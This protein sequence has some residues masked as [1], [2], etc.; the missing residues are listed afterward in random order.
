MK[1]PD[2]LTWRQYI[3]QAAFLWAV[4]FLIATAGCI[5]TGHFLRA[6]GCAVGVLGWLLLMYWMC[7][8]QK[9]FEERK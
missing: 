8:L 6:L 9:Q 4:V 3:A 1:N 2:D 7:W 5:L